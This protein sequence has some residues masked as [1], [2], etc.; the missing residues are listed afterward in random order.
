MT[1]WISFIYVSERDERKVYP[2]DT[3]EE[4][5]QIKRDS[6]DWEEVK[7]LCDPMEFLEDK[8]VFFGD[9]D[10]YHGV[11]WVKLWMKQLEEG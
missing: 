11:K 6:Q 10:Y 1:W 8:L 9:N 4:A 3:Y 2:V 5:L 7:I